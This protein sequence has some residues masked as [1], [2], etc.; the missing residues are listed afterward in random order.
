MGSHQMRHPRSTA[1]PSWPEDTYPAEAWPYTRRVFEVIV[2][3][4]GQNLVVCHRC[5][6]H[7]KNRDHGS[8]SFLVAKRG[9]QTRTQDHDAVDLGR[10]AQNTAS[11]DCTK[12]PLLDCVSTLSRVAAVGQYKLPRERE[13]ECALWLAPGIILKQPVPSVGHEKRTRRPCS[14]STEPRCVTRAATVS[15]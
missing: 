4:R 12:P 15:P 9:T 6:P 10:E 3:A 1:D 14:F 11:G 2:R 8:L 13:G 7:T 5:R